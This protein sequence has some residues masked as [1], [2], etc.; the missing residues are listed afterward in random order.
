LRE[1]SNFAP[2]FPVKDRDEMSES[3]IEADERDVHDL[4]MG[5]RDDATRT[6]SGRSGG[7]RRRSSAARSLG[8]TAATARGEDLEKVG[9]LRDGEARE[10]GLGKTKS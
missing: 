1:K 3:E 4:T 6:R 10:N 7:S 5:S 8:A 9:S 2:T